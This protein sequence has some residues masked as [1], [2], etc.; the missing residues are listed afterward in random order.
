V[1]VC[2]TVVVWLSGWVV[3]AGATIGAFTVS[4]APSLVA[5]PALLLTTTV[6]TDPLSESVVTGVWYVDDAAPLIAAPFF[7]H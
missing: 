7:C 2:P 5:L 4:I 1:A 6:N 3:I